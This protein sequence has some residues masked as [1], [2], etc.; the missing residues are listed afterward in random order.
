MGLG[1][2]DQMVPLRVFT[3]EWFRCIRIT[4]RRPV[5]WEQDVFAR[6]CVQK[7]HAEDDWLEWGFTSYLGVPPSAKS[8]VFF[9]IVQK[10]G[11]GG[12]SN[13]CSKNM[14]QILYD[15][16]GLLAT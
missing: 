11:W 4:M 5:C 8:T 16:K 6:Q 10:G 9:I 15:Y 7:L 14:L 2:K 13:P 3:V 12:G 1:I